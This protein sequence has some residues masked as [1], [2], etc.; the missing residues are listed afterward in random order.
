M[1]LRPGFL[2]LLLLLCWATVAIVVAALTTWWVLFAALP[3]L[4]MSGM[5]ML[6]MMGR[7]TRGDRRAGPREW[8]TAWFAPPE[9]RRWESEPR[10]GHSSR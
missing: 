1:W 5:T 10:L 9:E 2:G 6:R 7:S 8:C 4:V 3:L